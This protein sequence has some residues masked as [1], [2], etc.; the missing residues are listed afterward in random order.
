[1]KL[2][3]LDGFSK[4]IQISNFIKICPVGAQFLHAERHDK[5]NIAFR[6]FANAPTTNVYKIPVSLI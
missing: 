5:A 1:M 6:N 3:F 2:Y 4:N